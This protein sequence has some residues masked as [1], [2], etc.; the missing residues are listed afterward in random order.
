MP[1]LYMVATPIGN[2]EDMTYRAVRI[3]GEVDTIF[4]EDTRHSSGLF[5]H[6]GIKKPLVSLHSHN[7][8]AVAK[9]AVG[10]LEAGSDIAYVSDAG[11]PGVSDPGGKL[12]GAVREA[13][14]SIVPLPGAS[15]LTAMLSVAGMPGKTVVFEGFLPIKPGKRRKRLEELME[16]ENLTVLYESVYRIIN[17][18]NLVADID[19]ERQVIVGRELTKLHEEIV[20]GTASALAA[21]F[22][23]RPSVKGEFVVLLAKN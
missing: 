9:R 6:Y 22:A 18:L 5:N 3:L 8:D 15:A 21:E 10:L 16:T 20:T 13:G 2:L 23:G 1:V 17:L 19:P 4:C 7:E 12:V 11:T 14:F